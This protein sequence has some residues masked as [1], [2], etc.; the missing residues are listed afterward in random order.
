MV[1]P[2]QRDQVR[3]TLEKG[4]YLDSSSSDTVYVWEPKAIS[5]SADANLAMSFFGMRPFDPLQQRAGEMQSHANGGM[6]REDFDE[7]SVGLCVGALH[8]IVKISDGLVRM[9]E[10]Y[11][12][13][14]HGPGP[15]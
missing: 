2:S 12:L 6:P 8:Y 3:E 4:K 9:N 5:F 1:S 10:E 13:E 15:R 11:Q 14:L 7:R